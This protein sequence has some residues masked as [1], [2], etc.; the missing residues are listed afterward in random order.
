MQVPAELSNALLQSEICYSHMLG[1]GNPT[2]EQWE[3]IIQTM[4]DVRTRLQNAIA[5]TNKMYESNMQCAS[6]IIR[7]KRALCTAQEEIKTTKKC[8]KDR[9][10]SLLMLLQN[11]EKKQ[12]IWI[13][14]FV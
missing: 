1:I 14:H 11:R 13:K 4:G 10:E 12:R 6:M 5:S 3:Y 9:I 2:A 8:M 7:L